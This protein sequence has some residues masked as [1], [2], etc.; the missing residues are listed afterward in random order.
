V[1]WLKTWWPALAWA[2]VISG[3]STGA[4]TAEHTSRIIIPILHWLL[5]HAS[6]HSLNRIHHIIR[7]CAHFT[8]YFILSLLILRGIRAGRPGSRFAWA[9]AAIAIVACYAS[10]D[11]LHQ[12]FVP[13]RTAA[14]ADVLIDTTGGIAAQVV[15][16]IFL[17]WGHVR[18][19][20]K[21]PPGAETGA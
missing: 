17:V 21:E 7:K 19:K 6:V 2:V 1:N 12:H 13:G 20:R 3:F 14:V 18:Q 15:A 8:E 10:L 16:A 9:L 4:F 5:P 11:E